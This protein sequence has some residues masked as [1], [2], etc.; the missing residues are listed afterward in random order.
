MATFTSL[1]ALRKPSTADNINVELDLN[2]N[3][4][5][6]DDK[7]VALDATIATHE[8]R[9]DQLEGGSNE[10]LLAN[11]FDG[12]VFFPGTDNLATTG[13][14]STDGTRRIRIE[15]HWR[16]RC[17]AAGGTGHAG[18]IQR[19]TDGGAWTAVGDVAYVVYPSAA[20]DHSIYFETWE[21]PPSGSHQYRVQVVGHGI[22]GNA[23]SVIRTS[24]W[25][26]GY[27]V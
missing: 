2:E 14:F 27:D 23:M 26:A 1:L 22:N 9:I 13:S 21:T 24:V 6:I 4:E 10:K 7:F 19:S 8:T 18:Q 16:G 11:G 5:K 25:D 12:G 17:T 20:S 3:F 15:C